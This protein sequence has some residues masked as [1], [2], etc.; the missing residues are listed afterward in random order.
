MKEES[1][2]LRAAKAK[3]SYAV[4]ALKE[5]QKKMEEA[6]DAAIEAYEELLR[7]MANEAEKA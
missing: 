7:V 2:T 1:E 6:S 3:S 5:A 4:K